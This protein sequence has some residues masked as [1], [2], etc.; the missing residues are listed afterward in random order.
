MEDHSEVRPAAADEAAFVPV[1]DTNEDEANSGNMKCILSPVSLRIH[2]FV[3]L[4][5]DFELRRATVATIF[6]KWVMLTGSSSLAP[7]FIL[8]LELIGMF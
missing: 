5:E 8:L 4:L 2:D 1:W 3:L 7:N 6:E